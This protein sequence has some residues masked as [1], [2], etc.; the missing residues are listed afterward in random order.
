MKANT[1]DSE[2]HN[3]D[4]WFYSEK[5]DG[6][7]GLWNGKELI[8]KNN[9]AYTIPDFL[10]NE[11]SLFNLGSKTKSE[12]ESSIPCQI[13]DGEIWFGRGNFEI[14]SGQARKEIKDIDLWKKNMKFMIFDYVT[15]PNMTFIERRENLLRTYKSIISK[16]KLKYC[17]IVPWEILNIK[18][19]PLILGAMKKLGSEGIM[20]IN[21]NSK[22]VQK[23]TSN[24]LKIKF[25]DDEEGILIGYTEGTGKYKGKIGAYIIESNGIK[26]KLSG[27][28]DFGRQS[29]IL[30]V[31]SDYVFDIEKIDKYRKKMKIEPHIG[32]IVKYR[33]RDKTKFGVPRNASYLG[34]RED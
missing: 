23:R 24:I 11:L 5:Y 15:D 12:S 22:Y 27:M 33:Y 29:G 18:S 32:Q 28:T 26:F 7:R 20:V 1:Y 19:L 6:V 17:E 25:E 14:S 3:I 10:E 34:I 13:L 31:S 2:K 30:D 4:N 21:P 9:N 8:S 16:Y